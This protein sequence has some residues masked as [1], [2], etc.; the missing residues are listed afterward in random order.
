MLKCTDPEAGAMLYAYELNLL[1]EEDAKTFETHLFH[2]DF[3]HDQ[4]KAFEPE[5]IILNHDGDVKSSIEKNAMKD[6]PVKEARLKKIWNYIWPDKSLLLK[7]GFT[8]LLVLLMLVPSF[9]GLK[10]LLTNKVRAVHEF[11]LDSHRSAEVPVVEM[12]PEDALLIHFVLRDRVPGQ[13]YH[14]VIETENGRTIYSNTA[15]GDFDGRHRGKL[16]ISPDK[17][18]SEGYYLIVTDPSPSQPIHEWKYYFRI[19]FTP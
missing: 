3:C 8:Y 19:K 1:S 6:I 18:D 5:T 14:V 9:Y 10:K 13:S 16:I 12:D 7:P 2:C 15:F 17:I 4:I 11:T